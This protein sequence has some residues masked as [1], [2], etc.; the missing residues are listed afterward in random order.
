MTILPVPS[1]AWP[2]GGLGHVDGGESVACAASLAL[3]GLVAPTVAGALVIEWLGA[4]VLAFS[5]QTALLL[6]AGVAEQL[7]FAG[8]SMIGLGLLGKIDLGRRRRAVTEG[9]DADDRPG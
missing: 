7:G 3:L 9:S 6:V 2:G 5:E 8:S 4:T 1:L